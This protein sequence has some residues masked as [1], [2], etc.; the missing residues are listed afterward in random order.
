MLHGLYRVVRFND[1]LAGEEFEEPDDSQ[2]LRRAEFPL[3]CFIILLE[4]F[5]KIL[6]AIIKIY[7]FGVQFFSLQ[8]SICLALLRSFNLINIFVQ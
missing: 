1:K 3:F 8:A 7:L 5:L 4:L 2:N 6:K